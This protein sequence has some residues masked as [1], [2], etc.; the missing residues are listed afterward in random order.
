MNV[1]KLVK[2]YMPVNP[3]VTDA[4]VLPNYSGVDKTVRKDTDVKIKFNLEGGLMIK[5]LNNT[6][7]ASVKG[8]LVSSSPSVDNSFV[9][10]ANEFDTIGVVYESGI[11]NGAL[12][13]IVIQG[14]ADV[15]FKDG[16]TVVRGYLALAA[17]TDGRA[18]DIDVPSSNP[19]VAEH[20]KEIGHVLESKSA[21]TNVLAKVVLHFN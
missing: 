18:T 4:M 3:S 11:A 10:Q 14:I 21:G 15:L 19:V 2:H 9:L 20:F 1:N 5:L 13:W 12:C 16:D 7:S 17:D 8:S 6:G